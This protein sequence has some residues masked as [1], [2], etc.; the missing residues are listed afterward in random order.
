MLVKPLQLENAD[1]PI[2]VKL[3]GR[4]IFFTLLQPVNADFPIEVTLSGI[5]ILVKLLH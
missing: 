3:L 2:D 5:V 4:V 1:L